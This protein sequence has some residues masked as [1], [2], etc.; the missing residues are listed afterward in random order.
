MTAS[1]ETQQPKRHRD[2]TRRADSFIR[3]FWRLASP[4]WKTE[5]RW[6]ARGL[7][8]LLVA[9]TLAQV[10]VPVVINRWSAALFDALEQRSMD[11]F[12]AQIALLGGIIVMSM[13]VT[14]AHLRVKRRIQVEWR[15]WLTN[16]LIGEWMRGGRHYQL[17]HLAGEHDNPDQRIAEDIRNATE[18]AV[19]LAHSLFYSLVLLISFTQIL[20]E[21][22]GELTVTLFET[23]FSV[24]GH[25]VWAA[26]LY[27]SL[28][29][30][31]AMLLGLPL[32]GAANKR[33]TVE[34]DFRFG[35]VHARENSEAIAILHGEGD[36]R[37]RFRDLFANL[38]VGWDR[39]TGALA[40]ILVFTS[41]Y[42]VLSTAFP[43]IVAAPRYIT[44]AITLGSLMQTAQAFQQMAAALSWPIDNLARVAEWRASVER[45]LGLHTGLR[46]LEDEV[47]PGDP[48]AVRVETAATPLLAFRE[49]CIANP[50]GEVVIEGFDAEIAR[51]ERVLISGDSGAASKLFKVMAGVWPWGRGTIEKP[52]DV[53]IY[54]MPRRPYL[55][56]GTL[57]GALSYP[58]APDAFDD[59]ALRRV[60]E[61][62]GLAPL[63]SLLDVADAWEAHLTVDELQRLGFA[64]LLLQHPSW[65]FIQEATDA[66]DGE[67]EEQMMRL[68][69][70]EF[71]AATIITIGHHPALE[72]FHQ[73][74]LVLERCTDGHVL[75][76]EGHLR[77]NSDRGAEKPA[78]WRSWLMTLMRQR[79][80]TYD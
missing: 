12:L 8:A 43:V 28:G 33:Q 36:E 76:R 69:Q 16:R 46:R 62:V 72:D 58:S 25:M 63:G 24:P 42:S 29:T 56:L 64:R 44:G 15:R 54:F 22:S 13:A 45:V 70:K 74:K 73:R 27:A 37:R 39:Q 10:V 50:N 7:T 57:R 2:R 4:F 5:V 32:V 40:S 51:G 14:V 9:L 38:I 6:R 68:L 48:H 55:P 78:G 30:W 61:R 59:E 77:R 21:L 18:T 41:G 23:E 47:V 71:P 66:L 34:G 80:D 26:L 52:P 53:T 49:L 11:R 60:L 1:V 3:R 35:L 79:E 19:D 65:I 31:A 67:A 75:V 20:W 17:S